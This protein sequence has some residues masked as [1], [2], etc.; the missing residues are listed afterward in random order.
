MK[1]SRREL[2]RLI[3]SVINEA[4]RDDRDLYHG[5]PSVSQNYPEKAEKGTSVMS[6]GKYAYRHGKKFS[7]SL[8]KKDHLDHGDIILTAGIDQLPDEYSGDGAF[9]I[10]AFKGT[11]GEFPREN[12]GKYFYKDGQEAMVLKYNMKID[13]LGSAFY[14]GLRTM[15]I[16]HPSVEPPSIPK[17]PPHGLVKV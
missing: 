14:D 15:Y 3:E 10:I 9:N 7:P 17:K 13:P 2:R 1:L 12:R 8:R 5:K 11:K 6:R 16:F 4:G